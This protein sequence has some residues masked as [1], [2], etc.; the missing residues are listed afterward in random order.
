MMARRPRIQLLANIPGWAFDF[1]ARSVAARLA[2]RFEFSVAYCSLEP[3]LDPESFDLLYVF[4]WADTWYRRFG[5]ERSKIIKEVASYRWG[6]EDFF[7]RISCDEFVE[8]YLDDC[9][10]VTTPSVSLQQL[11]VQRRPETYLRSNGYEP[12]L[13]DYWRRRSG[14]LRIGW[15]GN[16]N[17]A[18][19]GLKDILIPACES[20]FHFE[21][22][23]GTWSRL[24]VSQFYNQIDV[25][26]VAS[27]A[28]GE[29]LPLIEALASG[30]FPVST[31]VGLAPELIRSGF[32]G[33]IVERS[34][35]AFRDAFAWC[36]AN[37]EFVRRAG[38]F[39]V[40]L[41]R[42]SRRWDDCAERFAEILT[43]ALERRKGRA[44]KVPVR[45]PLPTGTA[46]DLREI[47]DIGEFKIRLQSTPWP[48]RRSRMTRILGRVYW[49]LSDHRVHL[50]NW[51]SSSD[52]M[53]TIKSVA[54]R[55]LPRPVLLML[56]RVLVSR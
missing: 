48:S 31:D 29:P 13:F 52:P 38:A 24:R 10:I 42:E 49:M 7:G 51:W 50:L 47:A 55:V 18:S 25:I 39:N 53:E 21:Y 5:I 56:K 23:P 14:P 35:S 34:P 6:T 27:V 30:C 22:S 8:R 32:N 37:L 12:S 46:K 17:D 20:R 41:V 33:L 9:D 45:V 54:R 16:A 36:E 43:Y 19:K 11:L 2:D 28:E 1:T 26:A 40:Q 3:E 44:A 4:Y 15:V